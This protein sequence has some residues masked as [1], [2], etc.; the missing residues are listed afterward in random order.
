KLLVGY[1]TRHQM[2]AILDRTTGGEKAEIKPVLDGP[3]IVQ[4][5]QLVRRGII[6]PHVQDYA[7]RSVMATHPDG[8]LATSLSKQFLRFGASPRA[9]QSLVLGA[10]V[11]AL[12]DARAHVSVDDI[13][14]VMLPAMRHRILLNFE[15]QAEGMTTD[16]ILNDIIDNLKV[17]EMVRK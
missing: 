7:V 15:G 10:K 4:F 12:L 2:H 5:Q 9:A 13:K 14:K 6:A 1:S 3:A 16:M 8:E 17:E 11:A